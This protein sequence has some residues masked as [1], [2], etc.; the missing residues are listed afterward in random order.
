MRDYAIISPLFWTGRTG[1]ALRAHPDAQRLALYIITC[2]HA[3][4][5]GLFYLPL[6]TVAH[7][8]GGSFDVT[9][10][11]MAT[12]SN[13]MNVL[14]ELEFCEY[15]A[16]AEM[17]FVRSMARWQVG[18]S[19]KAG[20]KRIKGVSK[21]IAGKPPTYLTKLFWDEYRDDF[22][23]DDVGDFVP[24]DCPPPP[25]TAPGTNNPHSLTIEVSPP[26]DTTPK[27]AKYSEAFERFWLAWPKKLDKQD[28]GNVW[29]IKRLDGMVDEII[30]GVEKHKAHN[31]WRKEGGQFIPRAGKWLKRE[32]WTNELS[33]D[34]PVNDTPANGRSGGYMTVV[35]KNEAAMREVAEELLTNQY[36]PN[37][38]QEFTS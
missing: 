20:D 34:M 22:H 38:E 29:R 19:L 11:G 37:Y 23:L 13:A 31:D 8:V 1:R 16:D 35:E 28:A 36:G 26:P 14:R 33:I 7:E 5:T 9:A 15:D 25:V 27:L 21:A 32:G 17:V 30:E 2:P 3:D 12:L 6:V 24:D 10:K 4:M 18:K